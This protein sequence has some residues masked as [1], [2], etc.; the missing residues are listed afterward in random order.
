MRAPVAWCGGELG[1]RTARGA[2][3]CVSHKAEMEQQCLQRAKN[4]QGSRSAAACAE[5]ERRPLM[6]PSA[7][8]AAQCG[9]PVWPNEQPQPLELL[10][11]PHLF[12]PGWVEGAGQ[13]HRA[14]NVALHAVLGQHA[15]VHDGSI[16]EAQHAVIILL[17]SEAK[18]QALS[19]VL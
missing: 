16:Q 6:M 2:A 1:L 9:S 18:L 19:L 15:P 13:L 10:A 17:A 3:D 4:G 12:P 8:R 14:T 7:S 5:T 11:R